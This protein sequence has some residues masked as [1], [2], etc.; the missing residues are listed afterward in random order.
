MSHTKNFT[1]YAGVTVP[2]IKGGGGKGGGKIVPNSLFSTDILYLTTAI[3]EGPV[4]RIGPNGPQD[5]QIQ[6]S[7]IDDLLNLDTDGS[8]NNTKFLVASVSGTTTQNYIP[9]FGNETVTPQGFSSPVALKKGNINGV[10][11]S[12]ITEQETSANNWDTLKFTFIVN[13]LYKGDK[14]GNVKG[15]STTVL[16]AIYDYLMNPIISREI[17]ISGKTD[18]PFKQSVVIDIPQEIVN[19][20]VAVNGYK[21]S[22]SKVNDDTDDAYIKEDIRVIGWDEIKHVAQAFPRTAVVG[23]AIKA[24]DEHTGGVPNFTQMVKGLLVKVP[25][26]YN[27]PILANGE[28]DWRELEVPETGTTNIKGVTTT[29]GYTQKG[30][31]LQKS[32]PSTVLTA[33]NPQIYVGTWDGTFVYSWTQNPVWIIYDLLTNSTY[34]LGIPQ[35]NIDKFRF[36]QIAMYCDACD[37][38]TGRYMGVSGLA[39]GSYR[40]KPNTLY[41]AV[42]ENQLG[43]PSGTPIKERRFILDVSITEQE[44]A[45][46]ILNKLAA[47]FRALLIYAGGKIS[48]A[49]DMPEEYP[50]MLF[51][52]ATIKA[53]S[54]QISGNKESDIYTGVDV[55]YIEP[56]NHFK[57]ETVRINTADANDGTDTSDIENIA[58]IDL[59][60]VTRRS[61]ATRTGQYHIASSRYLRRNISFTTSTDALHLAPGDVISVSSQGTGVAY[62]YGGKVISNRNL[63]RYGSEMNNAAWYNNA[64]G[65]L[66]T[67]NAITAPDG[68]NTA[69]FLVATTAVVGHYISSPPEVLLIPGKTYYISVYLK[70]GTQTSAFISAAGLFSQY[71]SINLT[72][73]VLTNAPPGAY[74]EALPNGWWRCVFIGVA[75]SSSNYAQITIW[76]K[77]LGIVA[78]DGVSGIYAWGAQI[79]LDRLTTYQDISTLRPITLEHFTV[80]SISDEVF[81]QN[82][83]PIALRIIKQN[84][85]KLDTYIVSNTE[86]ELYSVGKASTGYDTAVVRVLSRFDPITKSI[87][88]LPTGFTAN[89][90]P[91]VG[92]LWSLGEI[93]NPNNLYSA[94]SGKL[95]KVT[96]LKRESGDEVTISAVEYIS[97]VYA[98]SDTF[99]NY[100]PT[101]YVDVSSPFSVPP[102]PIFNFS[103]VPKTRAD[104]TLAIDGV[105]KNRNEIKGYGQKFETEYFIASPEYSTIVTGILNQNPLTIAVQSSEGLV[106]GSYS[107]RLSGKTGFNSPIGELKLLCNNISQVAPDKIELTLEGLSS[108][109]D[110]NFNKHILDVNNGSIPQ[111]NG[112][113]FISLPVIEKVSANVQ[114][115]FVGY[116]SEL[117]EITQPIVSYSAN[118]VTITDS[119]AGIATLYNSLPTGSFY[120]KI[121]QV[122]AAN[123]Y[124]NNNFYIHGTSYTSTQEGLLDRNQSTNVLEL[125]VKPTHTDAV[126]LYIDGVLQTPDTINLNR[127]N[128]LKANI[129]YTLTASATNYRTEVDYY[130]VPTIEVG[131]SVEISHGN[132]FTVVGTS[133]QPTSNI[134]NAALTSNNIFNI[135]L[136]DSPT[137]DASG[138]NITNNS[139]NP[140]GVISNVSGNT[141]VL[142]Y[143]SDRYP[144]SFTLGNN[145]VYRLEVGSVFEKLFLA[146]DL[147]IPNL[148][149]GITTVRARNKNTLGRVSPF[150]EQSVEVLALPI[151]KVE[152]ISITESLYREQTGG[153]AVRITCAFDH[154]IN[155]Q[156][157]DYELSYKLESTQP[158]GA[159]DNTS[160]IS[161]YNTV[162]ISANG[163]TDDGKIHYTINNVNRG[164]QSGTVSITIKITP[165]NRT[166]RGITAVASKSIVGKTTLPAN[167]Y[168]FIGGQQNE[169]V[170]LLWQYERTPFG[171]LADLDL[172]EILIRRIP[173]SPNMST[174]TDR[175]I[176]YSAASPLVEVSAGSARKTVPIDN[177][178]EYTYLARTRDT[179]GNYS[180]DVAYFTI[181]TSRPQRNTIIAA[182]N[183]D[184]PTVNFANI[185]NNNSAEYNYPSFA[186]STTGGISYATSSAVDK[187]NGSS[188]GWST[189][190]GASTDLLATEQAIYTT[191][192]RDFGQIVTGSISIDSVYTQ[193]LQGSYNDQHEEVYSLV[194]EVS[195]DPAI[196]KDAGIGTLLGYA[197][198]GMNG[199]YDA[200]NKTWMTGATNG[201][202]W[203][204]WNHGAFVGDTA[205]ANSYALIAGLIN[206]N[207]IALGQSYYANGKATGGN[208]LANI[209]T[210]ISAYTLVNLNQY[211]DVGSMTY[212]GDIGSV[213]TQTFIRTA[214]SNVYYANGNVN[215]A[216]FAGGSAGDGFLPYEAGAK[217]FRYFQIKFVVNNS[218]PDE[219][220]FTLDRFRYTI[221][222]EQ[223]IYSNTVT[224]ASLPTTVNYSSAG[225]IT[226]PVISYAI[227][228]QKD[229]TANP[230]IVVTTALSNT[231]AS[232]RLF[233]SDGT[234]AYLANSSANVMVTV[235]GV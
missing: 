75:T 109:I 157:T 85:D 21:F 206:A 121:S 67:P 156:V 32:G 181:T 25:S 143:D 14:K 221:D 124:A 8:V 154:I 88:S 44:K 56:T 129:I 30:Y 18:T 36:Y 223:T 186:N 91:S 185:P 196:L 60:G 48:L 43:L 178:G 90:A 120:V 198:P 104:G 5:I 166:V 35:E 57:R 2:E 39:D 158:V 137:F 47:S 142:T 210:S 168:N 228:D 28:I 232:F 11:A 205:N 111:L 162:K 78:G 227:L 117:T 61:Q 167:I 149:L 170:T 6:D 81:T 211:S 114:P 103:A 23:Y 1:Q 70:A 64:S 200:N 203:A 214:T 148:P 138:F 234:G 106:D 80:P 179:S 130:T 102:T 165:L 40:N 147:V 108:C 207:A 176:A 4:Y 125:A 52:E 92:D 163:V 46:D 45:L 71:P 89:I 107:T 209:T 13:E 226:R 49:V 161:S 122:L 97:N 9:K 192:I 34:G 133:Y 128:S 195:S 17:S 182:Y 16:I 66:V 197:N 119:L 230:A 193:Q 27:Q 68:T 98:D 140:V 26:N 191:Q 217:Q 24:T 213:T 12:K 20:V 225:F 101:A 202:V 112:Q 126:R 7:S 160:G 231:S 84:S 222:K 215:V 59:M 220:D 146:D 212:V 53:G 189:I 201:N 183:E 73:G 171:E 235:I 127:F 219:F 100:E 216:V 42:R 31:R 177:F 37:A 87:V 113:N 204:I 51:N 145:A 41:T 175:L 132:T 29:T 93:S 159:E 190:F 86:Y 65:V 134:Y 82:T 83:Y 184:S 19:S 153:V 144:G 94:K 22:I 79:E 233:A 58:S 63:V 199:R 152:N 55:N 150:V 115:G 38:S 229:S 131:D 151:Q 77:N 208:A 10:P 105:L 172:K 15:Y 72:T 218:R 33:L 188:S 99:I 174:K 54:F 173:G 50:V 123:Y 76:P 96:G 136:S 95:F 62:G 116:Q 135:K 118:K 164:S 139:L 180:D 224:Y 141:C 187:A 69:D 74:T 194:S 3:G 110:V 155:Q 169:Q